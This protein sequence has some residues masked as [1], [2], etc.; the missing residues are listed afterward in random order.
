MLSKRWRPGSETVAPSATRKAPLLFPVPAPA[1]DS[2]APALTSTVPALSRSTARTACRAHPEQP[3]I[4]ESGAGNRVRCV[5]YASPAGEFER[6]KVAN[7]RSATRLDQHLAGSATIDDDRSVVADRA[8]SQ[9]QGSQPTGDEQ[10]RARGNRV[11]PL[12][13]I[14]PPS[15]T[16]AV[17]GKRERTRRR[18]CRRLG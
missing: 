4:L 14:P 13:V 17:S 12:P 1:R 9:R 7:E 18:G 6:A 16:V 11:V 8:L 5:A 2:L 3:L 10:I 15:P